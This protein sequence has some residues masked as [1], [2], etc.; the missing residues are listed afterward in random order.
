[1]NTST[2]AIKLPLLEVRNLSVSF[3]QQK[4]LAVDRVSLNIS[5][6]RTLGLVGASGAGNAASGHVK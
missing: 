2:H 1:M 6:G 3:H 5:A 4:Q